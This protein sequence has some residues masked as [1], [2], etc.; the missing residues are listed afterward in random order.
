VLN[1]VHMPGTD[2]KT[3]ADGFFTNNSITL[4]HIVE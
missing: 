3:M 2:A 1:T 4:D